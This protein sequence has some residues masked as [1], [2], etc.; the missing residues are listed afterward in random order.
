VHAIGSDCR[1]IVSLFRRREDT[2]L[3]ANTAA[4]SALRPEEGFLKMLLVTANLLGEFGE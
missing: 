1:I 3:L 4:G 2:H